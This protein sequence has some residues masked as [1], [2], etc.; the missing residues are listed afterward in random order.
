M[1]ANET[2]IVEEQLS[3]PISV[4]WDAITNLNS[5][6]KWYFNNIPSFKP[7]VGFKTQFKVKSEERSFLHLWEVVEVI[8]FK[9][10][11][12]N[13]KYAEYLGNSLVCFEL[14]ENNNSTKIRLTCK[15]TES[16]SDDIPEF[17]TESCR[18]G[19]NYF[20]KQ[21]LKNYLENS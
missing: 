12:Y 17:K 2:I 4:V 7:E 11:I 14:F 3:A 21:N 15:I 5:M 1:K 10:I 6:K 20:I 16:F 19:W 13:W 9:K 8:P 18:G